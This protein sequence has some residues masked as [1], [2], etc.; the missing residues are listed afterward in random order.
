MFEQCRPILVPMYLIEID[1]HHTVRI[2]E[3]N[4]LLQSVILKLQVIERN[5]QHVIDVAE[6]FL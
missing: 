2:K 6:S 5:I 3:F 1:T 4:Q